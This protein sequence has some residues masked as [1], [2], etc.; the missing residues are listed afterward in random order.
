MAPALIA[1]GLLAL[2]LP[3][4]AQRAPAP[5][6]TTLSADVLAL[7]CAPSLVYEAPPTP[8][9]ITGSQESCVHHTLA[10]GDLITIN[11]GTDNGV[12][13][14]Q[15]YYTR[16]AV[17]IEHRPISRANPATIRTT[18]WIRI[19]AV[20]RQAS[21]AT[22]AHACDS[23][24]LNDYLEPFVAPEIPA[25]STDRPEAQRGNYSRVLTGND[26][27][28]ALGRGDYFLVDRGS[29]HGVTVGA[30]F[31]VY[32]DKQQAGNFLFE[33]GEAVAVEVRPDSSTLRVTLSRD[34]FIAHDY[35][36]LRK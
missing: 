1:A 20:D 32:R 8:L 11:A 23:V 27:R 12:D 6:A 35:V 10:P 3:A 14:G 31:V 13:V 25:V 17:P 30:H 26:N 18:G 22:I 33:L 29:D 34:A 24:D 21:L 19:Y 28:T 7:A 15:V 2:A 5:E 36:A 9:R 16:R 4:I